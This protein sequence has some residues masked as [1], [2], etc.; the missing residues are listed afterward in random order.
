MSLRSLLGGA[1]PRNGVRMQAPVPYVGKYR[2]VNLFNFGGDRGRL[3]THEELEQYGEVST[4]FGVVSTLATSTALVN[5]RLFRKAA[6]GL[7]EDRTEVTSPGQSAPLRI[8]KKPNQFM[9]STRFV[10]SFQQHID[11]TGKAWWVVARAGSLPVEIW[12]VR[13]DR[14]YAVPSREDFIAGYVY[15]GPDGEQV[16]L[17]REDVISLL[18][19]AP[20]DV[21]DGMGPLGSLNADIANE[22]AQ[23]D[24]S[25]SFF[26]NSANPGGII[27]ETGPLDDDQF[28]ELVERWA[29]SH[30]G[31]SNA[32]RVAVLEQGK[33]TPLQYTQRD[34]QFVEGRQLTKQSILDAYAMPKFGIGDVQDVNR[35]SAE[36]SKAYIAESKTVP[37]LERIKDA[38]NGPFLELFGQHET[39]E[40]DYDSPVPPDQE[41]ENGTLTARAG[42]LADLIGIGFDPEEA[43][44][45]VGLPRMKYD[46]WRRLGVSI[47]GQE[48]A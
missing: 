9:T 14:I 3:A 25:Q 39:H 47:G 2:G 26:E 23:R 19:P 16:P 4:L 40:F 5:W 36:A 32:G 45:A 20:L 7:A 41:T 42:A 28:D 15:C 46:G 22:Q 29:R 30:R 1:M 44:D 37:R 38:L 10:E 17:L 6:S 21:Y 31:V 18:W 13:P 48:G 24:W 8:W 35:A 27:S 43:C 11:L 34:M 12:P 33:F